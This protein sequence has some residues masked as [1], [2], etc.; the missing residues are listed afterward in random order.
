MALSI[1][2]SDCSAGAGIQADCRTF[3]RL[4]VYGICALT[5][6][7]AQ[8]PGKVRSLEAV[9]GDLIG[10]Q[11]RE[12]EDA[13]P[14]AAAKTGLLPS[15]VAVEAV[16]GFCERH[17]E[18]PV[19]M[20]P[21]LRSGSGSTLTDDEV[22]RE[23]NRD[24]FSRAVL[25]TPNLNEAEQL[26]DV[27]I[28]E[29]EELQ[30]A[31]CRFSEVYGCDTLLKGGHLRNESN[32]VFDAVSIDGEGQLIPGSRLEIPDLHGTGCTLSAAIAARLARGQSLRDAILDARIDL[33]SWMEDYLSWK[34]K[35]EVHA[36]G[37]GDSDWDRE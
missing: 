25:V 14:I 26:L 21:V 35:R 29:P 2:G 20:D 16:L 36:I 37:I 19:V 23:M 32:T 27:V 5:C 8:S 17:P 30:A 24:L 9:S 13:F 22:K 31:A 12:L 4:G 11:L 10:A 7:V 3:E 1:A 33:R 34:G 28:E 18:V 6:V 15:R